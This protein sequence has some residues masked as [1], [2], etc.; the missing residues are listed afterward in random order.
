MNHMHD[1]LRTKGKSET[2]MRKINGN[3][4]SNEKKKNCLV[5]STAIKIWF[6]RR[7]GSGITKQWQA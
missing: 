1:K 4:I 7:E 2:L 3:I 5:I 6:I